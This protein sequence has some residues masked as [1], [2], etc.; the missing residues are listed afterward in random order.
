MWLLS[1]EQTGKRKEHGSQHV[2]SGG[3]SHFGILVNRRIR[4]GVFRI[5]VWFRFRVCFF[6]LFFLCTTGQK[7]DNAGCGATLEEPPVPNPRVAFEFVSVF[8]RWFVVKGKLWFGRHSPISHKGLE[9]YGP[10]DCAP[11][12]SF[13]W[14][15]APCKSLRRMIWRH[16][17]SHLASEA[18]DHV[19]LRVSLRAVAPISREMLSVFGNVLKAITAI[20]GR[21]F[22]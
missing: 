19:V 21:H 5:V 15:L 20:T 7:V 10:L 18:P 12:H 6:F 2:E 17:Q 3:L 4:F 16:H 9:S 1:L 8:G 13:Q 11:R 14:Q 22:E